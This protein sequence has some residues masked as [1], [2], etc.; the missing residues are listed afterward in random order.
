MTTTAIS[1]VGQSSNP[2][3]SSAPKAGISAD[4]DTFLKMM[5]TQM[6]NQDPLNPVNSSD[7]A[8]QLATF[9][10]VEQQIKTND[11][12]GGLGSQFGVMGMAQLAAW[13]GQEARSAA[14]VNLGAEPISISYAPAVTADQAVLVVRNTNGD[15]VAREDVS[16]DGESYQW[17]GADSKGDPLPQGRYSLSMESYRDGEQIG[18]AS[19]VETYARILEARGGAAGPTLVLDGGVSVAAT[20][21]T[22][23]RVP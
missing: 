13:V 3:T 6:T 22:A 23:L 5:T 9:S 2:T 21:I 8:V 11:L 10:S 16:L 4:F 20:E 1:S 7:F 12:L 18:T 14:P 19:P 15:V 17:F